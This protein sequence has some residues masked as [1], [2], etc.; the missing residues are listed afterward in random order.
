[1]IT[2]GNRPKKT[3]VDQGTEFAGEFKKFCAAMIIEK[4]SRKS[5]TK[6]ALAERTVRSF[7]NLT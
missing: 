7:K 5:E 3:W 6:A 1:M 4:H 2:I